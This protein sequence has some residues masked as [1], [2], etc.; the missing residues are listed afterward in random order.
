MNVLRY[1]DLARSVAEAGHEIGNH[2]FSHPRLC[3]RLGRNP[4]FVS[5][6]E[7]L[8][9][10][11]LAQEIILNMT[12]VAPRWLRAPYGMRWFGVRAAQ[13][14]LG[15][16]GAYWTAIGHDWEWSAGRVA[17]HVLR[18]VAPGGIICL[19]D[20]RDTQAAPDIS[21]TLRAVPLIVSRLRA[22]GYRFE[23]VSE[24]VRT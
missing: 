9:E 21:S 18:H 4:N 23:T 5:T 3:P 11:E 14:R 22:L 19:H 20:G 6:A 12:G 15:L 2:T 7:V 8:Q 10:F 13:K 1:P 17:E 16:K 24:I